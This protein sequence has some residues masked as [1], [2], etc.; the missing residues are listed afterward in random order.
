MPRA[1][2]AFVKKIEIHVT[3]IDLCEGDTFYTLYR[4]GADINRE[5]GE[6]VATLYMLET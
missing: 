5:G 1:Y 3:V 6:S 2:S 4:I